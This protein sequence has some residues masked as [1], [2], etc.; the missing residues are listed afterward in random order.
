MILIKTR[1][2]FQTELFV[3][4]CSLYMVFKFIILAL[5]AVSITRHVL[6]FSEA[7]CFKYAFIP[8]GKMKMSLESDS[9]IFMKL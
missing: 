2:R 8:E 4:S 1:N 5:M 7:L 3:C 9:I 6:S